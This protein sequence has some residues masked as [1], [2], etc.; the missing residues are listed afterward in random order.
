MGENGNTRA[1]L[2]EIFWTETYPQ[3]PPIISMNAFLN[4]TISPAVKQS[5][6]PRLQVV[7]DVNLGTAMTYRLLAFAKDNKDQFMENHHPVQAT[8]SINNIITVETPNSALPSK[9]K[10]KKR[11]TF[12]SPETQAGRQNRPQRRTSL[13][14]ELGGYGEAFKQIWL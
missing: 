2:I 1:F 9:K 7:M 8:T 11:A 5:I 10:E 14:L 3:K 4:N 6:L 12:Q 13:R